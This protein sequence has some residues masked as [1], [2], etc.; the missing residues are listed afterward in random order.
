MISR[1]QIAEIRLHL[2]GSQNPLFFFDNDV[3]GLCAFLILRRAL[4][5][6]K[7]VPIKSFPDLKGQY[8]RKVEEINPDAVFVLDKAEVSEEFVDG[9]KKSGLPI[10]WIDHHE[11]KTSNEIISQT[12]YY[13]SAPESEPVTYLAQKVFNRKEDLWLAM[14]G[15]I[16]DV[17]MPDFAEEFSRDFPELFNSKIS[18]FD[19]L[20]CTEIGKVVRMLNFGLMDT[21]TNVMNLIRYLFKAEGVYGILE[22]NG[23]TRSF[24]KRYEKLNE[25]Y[26][27]QVEKAEADLS[28][29]G[30]L[31]FSYSGGVSMSS[32]IANGIYFRHKDK[33]VVV[34]FKKPEKINISMRGKNALGITKKVLKKI[35]DGTGGGHPEATGA[36]IP[37]D[38]WEEFKSEVR[39][40]IGRL[41]NPVNP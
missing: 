18:A 27:K 2:E 17:Y 14:I 32:E 33:L 15:C 13:N 30:V 6:G 10:I 4:G 29:S 24:H 28:D 16:G 7:G 8:L 37:P 9:V 19:A 12:F 21:T 40:E 22:E 36:T 11:T 5:R 20:H 1:E 26:K 38:K 31:F 23:Y 3:D 41:D 34:A 25:F 35:G 39:D